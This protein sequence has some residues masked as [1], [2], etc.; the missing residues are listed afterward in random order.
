MLFR[1]VTYFMSP[2]DE[3]RKVIVSEDNEGAIQLASNSLSSSRLKHIH[4]RNHF[5]GHEIRAGNAAVAHIKSL[6]QYHDRMTE[7]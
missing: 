6:D 5:I 7:G 1:S 2:T 3:E 4:V